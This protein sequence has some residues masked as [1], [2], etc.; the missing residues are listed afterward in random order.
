VS[1]EGENTIYLCEGKKELKR[2]SF[3]KVVGE[4]VEIQNYADFVY[5]FGSTESFFTDENVKE[6]VRSVI[7]PHTLTDRDMIFRNSKTRHSRFFQ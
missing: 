3:G 7:G 4:A 6:R 2:R 5:A 1:N